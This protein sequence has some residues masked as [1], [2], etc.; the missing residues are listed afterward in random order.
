MSCAAWLPPSCP[1][2]YSPPGKNQ[3]ACWMMGSMTATTC[4]EV[5]AAISASVLQRRPAA[6]TGRPAGRAGARL[7]FSRREMFKR[8]R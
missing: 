2:E 1:R 3:S 8:K 7:P 5:A 6:V 4:T